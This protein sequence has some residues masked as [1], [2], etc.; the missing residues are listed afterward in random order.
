MA[1]T[2]SELKTLRHRC[3]TDLKFLC[4]NILGMK[5]WQDGL[6]DELAAFL[7]SPG[8]RK[9]VLVPRYHLKSSIVSVGWII[10]QIL[11]DFNSAI[12][13][14]NA[15][16]KRAEELLGQIQGYLTDKSL[17]SEIYGPFQNTR[18]SWT[19]EKLTIAQRTSGTV[20][21][22]TVSI[23]SPTTNVTGGHYTLV[24]NDDLV[25]RANTAT[26]DQIQKIKNFYKDV[27]NLSPKSPIITIG[28][29]WAMSDLYGDLLK[30]KFHK[31][32]V[33]AAL[34]AGG[35]VIFPNM[36]CKD[37][38]DPEWE[39]KICLE[40][41]K[42]ILG[43]YEYS[44]QFLNNPIDEESVEFKSHWMQQYNLTPSEQIEL[45]MAPGIMS[46]DPAV[47]LKQ[48]N[49]PVG[50]VVVKFIKGR[51]YIVEA[52]QKHLD[53]DGLVKEVFRLRKL[54]NV[55]KVLLETVAAQ[56]VF[57]TVFKREM[58]DRKDFF[59]IDEVNGG[60]KESK[61]AKIRGLLPYYANG[62][63]YHRPGLSDLED[64]L[65][66]FPRNTHDDVIDAL[67]QSIPYWSF[68]KEAEAARN[69]APHGSLNWWKKQRGSGTEDR[70]TKLFSDFIQ[71]G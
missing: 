13:I 37:R 22:P 51:V 65:T 45:E 41:Q 34:D 54:F 24:L 52:F 9:V 32:F 64:Q 19:T 38:T 29:R 50:I 61:A 5:D 25:E 67:A 14:T 40:A 58:I 12:L 62:M 8:N 39:M 31:A 11:R 15:T 55:K 63:V 18:T 44:C 66:Q 49:D 23:A 35:Q 27:I 43:P 20:K 6:H 60:T 4:K 48:S 59:T 68:N 1:L 3:E 46:I 36:V 69:N 30:N 33:R 57:M 16:L 17:L 2:A 26:P 70:F 53:P 56:L 71:R 47:T 21:E 7:D 10:Q 28:T 42:E